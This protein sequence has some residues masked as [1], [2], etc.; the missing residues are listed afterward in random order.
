LSDHLFDAQLSAS[1]RAF[2]RQWARCAT[3][4]NVLEHEEEYIAGRGEKRQERV[5]PAWVGYGTGFSGSTQGI[6]SVTALGR[7]YDVRP[8]IDAALA[9]YDPLL[10]EYRRLKAAQM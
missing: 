6:T 9:C 2:K 5:D 1:A 3:L 4:R 10:A 7:N 8:A